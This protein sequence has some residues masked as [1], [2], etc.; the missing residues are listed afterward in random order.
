MTKTVVKVGGS[1]YDLPDLRL[2]LRHWLAGHSAASV[3]LVPGGGA[4]ADVL[5]DLDRTHHLGEAVSH[6]LALQSLTVSAAFLSALLDDAPIVASP[7][8][9][10]TGVAILDAAAFCARD[11]GQDSL[12]ASWDATSDSIAARAALVAD[13]DELILLKSVDVPETVS[14]QEAAKGGMV[15][16]LFPSLAARIRKV[17]AVNLRAMALSGGA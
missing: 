15:D 13:A 14:W 4:T 8:D 12:P 9:R 17:S 1:L 5:R 2:R 16:P 3:L 7:L 10:W 6:Q 11:T